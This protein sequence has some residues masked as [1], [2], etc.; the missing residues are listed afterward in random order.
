MLLLLLIFIL[1]YHSNLYSIP[2]FNEENEGRKKVN[3]IQIKGNIRFSSKSLKRLFKT[4]ESH[5]Y[6]TSWYAPDVFQEDLKKLIDFYNS[7]GYFDVKLENI[8]IRDSSHQS[9]ALDISFEVVEGEPTRVKSLGF[10]GISVVDQQSLILILSLNNG[11]VFKR[12]NLVRDVWALINY[13]SNLSYI[14]V[15]VHPEITFDKMSKHISIVFVINEGEPNYLGKIYI[16]GNHRTKKEFILRHF[17]IQ[18]GNVFNYDV[19]LKTQ[20]RLYETNLFKNVSIRPAPLETSEAKKRDLYVNLNERN[21]GRF[22]MGAGYETEQKFRGTI[23]LSHENLAGIGRK[24]GLNLSIN[25]QFQ[26]ADMTFTEPSLFSRILLDSR[27]FLEDTEEIKPFDQKQYGGGITLSRLFKPIYNIAFSYQLKWLKVID[28][29]GDSLLT[30][31]TELSGNIGLGLNRDTRDDLFNTTNGSY[32]EIRLETKGNLIQAADQFIR[33]TV[34]QRLFRQIG[35][36]LV[37]AFLGKTGSLWR[38]GEESIPVFERFFAGGE[39]SVRGFEKNQLGP[40]PVN[41]FPKGGNSLFVGSLELRFPIVKSVGG[42]IFTDFGNVWPGWGDFNISDIRIT[43]GWGLR[44]NFFIGIA[45]IDYGWKLDR[46]SDESI[47]EFYL[48]IGQFF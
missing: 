27:F 20:K 7:Q 47:G 13:Y 17:A 21:P 23:S 31:N 24:A 30:D 16:N 3:Q 15:K 1:S 22:S 36:D 9:N 46:R 32:S 25:S 48:S 2:F 44:Y 34:E 35:G 28:M 37:L 42:A 41:E 5:F 6:H 39:K 11:D 26:K 12:D 4:K 38:I 45:R 19:I 18:S 14:D 10:T 40:G 8:K 43:F 29:E 33:L